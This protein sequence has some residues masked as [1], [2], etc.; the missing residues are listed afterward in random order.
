MA[1]E[2]LNVLHTDAVKSGGRTRFAECVERTPR[3]LARGVRSRVLTTTCPG[4]CWTPW[5]RAGRRLSPHWRGSWP[6]APGVTSTPSTVPADALAYHGEL[7]V[8]VEA[9]R[10]AWP[11]VKSSDNVVPWGISEFAENGVNHEIYDYLEHTAAPDPADAVLL[12]RVHFFIEKPREEYLRE[13]IGDLTG[14]SGRS[15]RR[16]TSP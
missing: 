6:P 10:I 12:D 8:L 1:F 2:M 14:K 13:F 9:L 16:T 11:F 7:S 4:A 3:A 5:R 15:G